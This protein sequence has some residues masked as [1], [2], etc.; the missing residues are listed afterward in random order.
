MS[1]LAVMPLPTDGNDVPVTVRAALR[2]APLARAAPEVLAGRAGLDR[3]IRW[4]H[5]GEVPDMPAML[6]GGELLLTT[7]MGLGA[8]DAQRRR[9]VEELADRGVAALAIELGRTYR[10]L[11]AALVRTAEARG[12]P[13]IALHREVRFVEVTEAVHRA[14]VGRQHLLMRRGEELHERF[15]ALM[16]GG[17]GI[18][19]VLA[20]LAHTIA[21]PVVLEKTGEGVLYHA[22][23]HADHGAV[24]AAHEAFARGQADTPPT[25]AQPV[26]MSD[27]EP[28]GRLVAL[29]ID[30][31][32]GDFEE[33]AVGRAVGLIALAL[34]R[35]RQEELLAA[36]ERGD[37]LAGLL[38]AADPLDEAEARNR[39]AAFGFR[40]ALALPL[41]V[42]AGSTAGDETGALLRREVE[43]GLRD[44]G[45]AALVGADPPDHALLMVLGLRAPE[46][47]DRLAELAAGLV[48]DAAARHRPGART[49]VCAGAAGR[50]WAAIRDGLSAAAHA[51][52]A[53]RQGTPRPWH[54]AARP[55]LDR[56]L[57]ALR[58]QADL[59]AFA[60]ARLA[61]LADH[62]RG[63]QLIATLDA[64][65][66]SGGR[67]ADAARALH[68]ERQ[69][70]YHRLRRIEELLGVDLADG[71]T[72]F[73]LQLALEARRAASP[74]PAERSGPDRGCRARWAR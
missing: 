44:R 17:A 49:V 29:G 1:E 30:S 47:R 39:A 54:D 66:A 38:G 13:L 74:T 35:S 11:P 14:I 52:P 9:F 8:T 23:H 28:W 42:S 12:L 40:A 6:R 36:R 26:P 50:S 70:L 19:E 72:R 67:K 59:R 68:L 64:Y 4:A 7:G 61:P 58:D 46:D 43:Q 65:F 69:S 53:A 21:N 73:E 60:Q 41:A 48:H 51:L 3:P 22:V 37:F 16:L 57:F 18:P 20:A 34:L 55:D 31:P 2:L 27:G 45:V 56:L 5:A 71:R 25:I 10:Q 32:L 33:V 63:E 15:T 62:R 24:L